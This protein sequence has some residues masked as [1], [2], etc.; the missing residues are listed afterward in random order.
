MTSDGSRS[1]E[2]ILPESLGNQDHTLP[3]G[4]VCDSCN[5]YFASS[6]EQPVLESGYFRTS[7]F[8]RLI[9]SKRRR[10]PALS[11][12][13]LPGFQTEGRFGFHRAEVSRDTD[14][15]FQIYPEAGAEARVATGEVNRVIIPAS[16]QKPRGQLFPRFLGKVAIECMG[17]R[18][19]RNAPHLLPDFVDDTQIDLLR[20]YARF[21]K[22]G[23]EWPYSERQIY[24][25]DF[26]FPASC[27]EPY[28]VLHE[29]DFLSTEET[30]VYFVIAILGI[31]Y[32]IN[33]AGPELE[34]YGL[35]LQRNYDRSP[36]YPG[37]LSTT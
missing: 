7:R 36:L 32:A 1:L 4:V 21:G 18:L 35:W 19:V 23:F 22:T 11:G 27:A 25:A 15:K 14:G 17:Q 31:E 16:G 20:N 2:H 5:N 10:I 33:M 37:G 13:L 30:E 8:N 28:E 34:G 12:I 9:P 29:W 24:P 26:L 6:I 3:A